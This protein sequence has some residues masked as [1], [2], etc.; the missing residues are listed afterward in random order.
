[1]EQVGAGALDTAVF[2]HIVLLSKH[3]AINGVGDAVPKTGLA[4]VNERARENRLAFGRERNFNRIVH[5]A[6]HDDIEVRAVGSRAVNVGSLVVQTATVAEYVA[7]L[8][9]GPFG[10]VEIAIRTEVGAMHVVGTAG[11]RAAFPPFFALVR[12]T[13]AVGVGEFPDARR[14]G[15]VKGS[16]VPETALREHHLVGEHDRFFEASVAVC[17]FQTHDAVGWVRKLLVRLLVRAGGIRDVEPALVIETGADRPLHQRWACYELD[18]KTIRN[19]ERLRGEF[20]LRREG[21]GSN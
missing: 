20:E 18:L 19:S 11:E 7:L 3:T 6:R 2:E 13:V 8:G 17:V 16:V 21:N 9:E 10:P 15:D 12:N 4:E 5:A 1:M 14:T